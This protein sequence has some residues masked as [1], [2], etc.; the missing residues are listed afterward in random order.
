MRTFIFTSWAAALAIV[1][2]LTVSSAGF[3]Q[4][5]VCQVTGT[6]QSNT[7]P[8]PT[9]GPLWSNVKIGDM[10]RLRTGGRLMTVRAIKG[11]QAICGWRNLSG[12]RVHANFPIDQLMVIG[13]PGQNQNPYSE[14]QPYRPCPADVVT[15]GGR[16]EC[17]DEKS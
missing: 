15:P 7:T 11:D 14:P 10:V 16:H 8:P 2:A 13:G 6:A 1:T 3:A 4:T 12:Q 5:A 9:F 17:L